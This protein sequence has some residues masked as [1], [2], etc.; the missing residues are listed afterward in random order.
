MKQKYYLYSIAIGI[1][2]SIMLTF[3]SILS[4]NLGNI[5]GVFFVHVVGLITVTSIM[6]LKKVKWTSLKGIPKHLL[7]PGMIG[8]TMIIMNNLTMSKIGLSLTVAS[9][10]FGQ[11][12][13]SSVVDHFGFFGNEV[14]K[15]NKKQITGYLIIITGILTM[16]L[17]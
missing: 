7:I 12:I 17:L 2:L 14:Y 9:G 13:C 5:Q 8:V 16:V 1:M 11:M 3:N 4:T 6:V 10:I 15:F